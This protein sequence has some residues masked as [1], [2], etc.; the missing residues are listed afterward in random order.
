MSL[1]P[2]YGLGAVSMGL[3][4]FPGQGSEKACQTRVLF[5]L[6]AVAVSSVSLLCSECM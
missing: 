4:S 1:R 6:L 5:F 2:P 3:A